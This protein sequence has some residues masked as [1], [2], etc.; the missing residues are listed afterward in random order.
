MNVYAEAIERA[1]RKVLEV[2]ARPPRVVLSGA[3]VLALSPSDIVHL[4]NTREDRAE[5]DA[6]VPCAECGERHWQRVSVTRCG[7][8]AYGSWVWWD[9]ETLKNLC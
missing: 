3:E 6:Q 7:I 1:K 2:I 4:A 5:I 9:G 8:D